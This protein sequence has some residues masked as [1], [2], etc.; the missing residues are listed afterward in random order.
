[1]KIV[2]VRLPEDVIKYVRKQSRIR[3]SDQSSIL[4]ELIQRG[5]VAESIEAPRST[6]TDNFVIQI[7]CLVKRLAGHVDEEIV[8]KAI[9][10]AKR[11][12]NKRNNTE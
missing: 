1:M 11:T 7:L 4:R 6:E 3:S 9:E 2:T 5:M 12:L 10:D 8:V